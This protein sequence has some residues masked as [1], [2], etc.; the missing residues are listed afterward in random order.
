VPVLVVS[1]VL[2]YCLSFAYLTAPL[3]V[4]KYTLLLDTTRK[5]IVALTAQ[6]HP[7]KQT[8]RQYLNI[9]KSL[10]CSSVPPALAFLLNHPLPVNHASAMMLTGLPGIGT[11]KAERIIQLRES[12]GR[13]STSQSLTQVKGIGEKLA[14]QLEPFLCYD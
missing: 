1:G 13:I 9:I 2:L 12:L 7:Q 4:K 14:A 11:K 6:Q 10:N 8:A 5:E 3:S